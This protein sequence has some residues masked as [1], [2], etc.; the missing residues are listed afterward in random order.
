[1]IAPGS[2]RVLLVL[3][4][5]TPVLAGERVHTVEPGDSASAI[6]KRYYGRH[7]RAELLLRYND[8]SSTV[9][10]PGERLRVPFCDVHHVRA[11]DTWSGLTRRY[12]GRASAWKAVAELNGRQPQRPLQVG[13]RLVFPVEIEHRLE[14]GE[15]LAALA[16]RFLGDPR[17]ADLLQRFN[18]LDD[19]RRLAV[20]EP[21]R[22]PVLSLRLIEASPPKPPSPRETS[23]PKPNRLPSRP[24]AEEPS[25]PERRFASELI[26]AENFWRAGD[27]ERTRE[28]LESL[29]EPVARRGAPEDRQ[30]L[31]RLLAFVY[32]AFDRPE[33]AC[34]ALETLSAREET[35]AGLDPDRVSPKIRA[36]LESCPPAKASVAAPSSGG[37]AK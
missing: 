3:S 24:V 25:G 6:A 37:S 4:L 19:P 10:R 22:I 20:G 8:R 7:D 1:M 34:A 18:G 16:A 21:V 2:V 23:P 11:G 30:Q 29:R 9:I 28:R 15:S 5:A 36:V 14:R 27:Y 33:R 31:A 12:L 26:E 17:R 35:I 13:E 32:V